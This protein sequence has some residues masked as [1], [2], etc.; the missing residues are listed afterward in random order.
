VPVGLTLQIFPTGCRHLADAVEQFLSGV[1]TEALRELDH[2][3]QETI[4]ERF[5]ALVH[6]CLTSANVLKNVELDLVQTAEEF[7]AE[8]IGELS[9]AE[10]FLEQQADAEAARAEIAGYYQEAAPELA[11]G[12]DG[13]PD[14]VCLLATPPGD[15][16][17]RFRRLAQEAL[18][19]VEWS[20]VGGVEDVL[21]CRERSHLPLAELE[22]LGPLGQDAYRQMS[23][24]EDFTPH[25]RI[26]VEFT[27][28]P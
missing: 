3:L 8:Q 11:R 15:A 19:D 7:A 9:V 17:E 1:G 16:G 28:Y 12:P 22:Q 4:R 6:F 18:P 10:M 14:E 25:T 24:A 27:S 23:A 21:I 2:R 26:D 13:S 20:T 5:C